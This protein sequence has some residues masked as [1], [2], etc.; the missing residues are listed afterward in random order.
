MPK[1][2]VIQLSDNTVTNIIVATDTD[3]APIGCE[4]K[5]ID[6]IYCNIG[7]VWNGTEFIDPNPVIEEIPVED[8]T[9]GS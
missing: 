9:N 4:L 2:A 1:C 7:F 6:G 5:I 3:P 8:S